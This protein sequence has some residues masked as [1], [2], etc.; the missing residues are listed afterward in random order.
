MYI[1]T[2]EL[3]EET[4]YRDKELDRLLSFYPTSTFT[5]SNEIIYVFAVFSLEIGKQNTDEYGFILREILKKQLKWSKR[6]E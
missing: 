3:E 5:F 2:R 4:G 1:I 6:I